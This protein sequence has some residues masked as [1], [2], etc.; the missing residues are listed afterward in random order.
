MEE[1]STYMWILEE[2][3]VKGLRR[4]LLMQGQI[5]FGAPDDSVKTRIEGIEELDTLYHLL[6]RVHGASSWS[7]LLSDVN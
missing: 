6:K 2:G 7:E 3:E 4:T 5:L 1:S